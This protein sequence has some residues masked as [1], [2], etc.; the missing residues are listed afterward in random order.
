MTTAAAPTNAQILSKLSEVMTEINAVKTQHAQISAVRDAGVQVPHVVPGPGNIDAML[1]SRQAPRFRAGPSVLSSNG[2]Q[3]GRLLSTIVDPSAETF[4]R[5]KNE[6]RLSSQ[7][8]GVI[9]DRFTNFTQ[10]GNYKGK[11]GYCMA[12]L[13]PEA[14]SGEVMDDTTFWEMKTMLQAGADYSDP[15]ELDFWRKKAAP[16]PAQS[17]TDQQYGGSFVPPPTFGPPIEL[18][19]NREALLN[20]G[21]TVIPLGPSGRVTYPR[22]VTPTTASG[23]LENTQ[24]TATTVTT[25]SLNINARKMMCNVLLP[26]ELLRY[27]APATEALIR[28][29]IFKSVALQLDYYLLVGNGSQTQPL[30][31]WTM[32]QVTGNT[33]AVGLVTPQGTGN[34]QLAPQDVF[35][36]PAQ[37]EA[38]NGDP[39]TDKGGWIMHPKLFYAFGKTRW[40]PYNGAG[41]VGGF[42]YNLTRGLA[43]G[44]QKPMLGDFP[45][46][47]TTQVTANLTSGSNTTYCIFAPWEDY[48]LALYGAI[49][50]FQTDAGY[51]LASSD[52]SLVRAILSGDG[53]PR[54]PGVFVFPSVG[55][56]TDTVGP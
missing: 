36:F 34:T 2:F 49:E 5:A 46:T 39:Y 16:T 33:Y 44:F 32:S 19:R 24:L 3:F 8:Q 45:V 28:A 11:A 51:T 14:F 20:A 55:V 37:C 56:T 43:D 29:D 9:Y 25:G 15:D 47:K 53:G 41:Q 18:L 23:Q 1:T 10:N 30:G 7:M 4:A 22:L 17:Y 40:T 21:A 26:N 52:M 42:V 31:L 35:A 13:W 54:H 12:P 38:N 6:L 50:F 48:I 27:G